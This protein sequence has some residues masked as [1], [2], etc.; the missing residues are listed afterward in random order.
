MDC[1]NKPY[2]HN[3]RGNKKGSARGRVPQ[4]KV[5]NPEHYYINAYFRSSVQVYERRQS[6]M[7]DL[8]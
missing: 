8:L 1:G 6:D 2:R 3:N 5:F 4:W 7:G